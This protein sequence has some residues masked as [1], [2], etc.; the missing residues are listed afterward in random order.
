MIKWKKFEN[1]YNLE[2]YDMTLVELNEQLIV[3][4]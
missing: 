2:E 1:E 3:N 4:N